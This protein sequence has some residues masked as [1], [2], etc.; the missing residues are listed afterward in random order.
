MAVLS[1][2][3]LSTARWDF[4]IENDKKWVG[5]VNLEFSREVKPV[6]ADLGLHPSLTCG[7]L[8]RVESLWGWVGPESQRGTGLQK[9]ERGTL[10]GGW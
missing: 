7:L 9:G 4:D 8:V 10:S 6:D 3:G 2:R 5:H 1:G